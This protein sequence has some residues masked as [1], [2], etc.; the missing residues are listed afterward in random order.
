MLSLRHYPWGAL[1]TLSFQKSEI[2]QASKLPTG[3]SSSGMVTHVKYHLCE[4]KAAEAFGKLYFMCFSQWIT[5]SF[6]ILEAN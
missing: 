2:K 6:S 4:S 5:L 1:E 3:A